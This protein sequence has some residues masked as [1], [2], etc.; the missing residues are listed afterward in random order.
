MGDLGALIDRAVGRG[1]LGLFRVLLRLP[2]RLLQLLARVGNFVLLQV[3]GR[4]G[5]IGVGAAAA[6]QDEAGDQAG[7]EQ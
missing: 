1:D 4:R 7:S 6:G 3:R 5:R 2:L